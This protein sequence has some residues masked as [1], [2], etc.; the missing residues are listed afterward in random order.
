M[1]QFLFTL[2]LLYSTPLTFNAQLSW[3][4]T[5]GPYGSA[6]NRLKSINNEVYCATY[7]GIYSTN[8]NGV[9]WTSRNNGLDGCVDFQDIEVINNKLIAG[10]SNWGGFITYEPGI[11]ISND[12]GL[13]WT[14]SNT[15]LLDGSPL[16]D[17]HLSIRDIFINGNDILIGTQDG[18][19]K[20]TNFGQSWAPS[21]IGINEPN[22]IQAL[23][24][25]KSG[26]A[27]FLETA[28]DIYKSIDN[29]FTWIDLNNNIGANPFSLVANSA[30]LFCTGSLGLYKSTNNGTS[31]QLVANNLP[32]LPTQLYESNGV[33]Y[34]AIPNIGT[35][36]STNNGVSW[37]VFDSEWYNDF[38]FINNT[39]YVCNN[40]GVLSCNTNLSFVN[41]GLGEAYLTN[42]LYVDGD[43]IY[44]GTENG[45]YKSTDDG[46]LWKNMR[47]GLP[48]STNVKCITK[49][50]PS[51]IIGTKDSGVYISTDNGGTWTQ[52]N[53]GLIL[54]GTN[55]WNISMLYSINGK[56]YVGAKQ[57]S[58][59]YD[60]AALFVSNNNGQSWTPV[61]TG[62]GDN[63]FITS[64]SSFGNYL[65]LGTKTEFSPPSFSDGVYLSTDSGSSWLFDG[66]DLPITD[67]ASDNNGYYAISGLSVY[68]TLNMGNT[69]EENVL[70]TVNYPLTGIEKLNSIVVAQTPNSGLLYLNNGNWVPI[71]SFGLLGGPNKAICQKQN[72]NM[73]IGASAYT[74]ANNGNITYVS[75]GVSKY[76][77]GTVGLDKIE[78]TQIKYYPNP[79]NSKIILD[80]PETYIGNQLE[81]YD[82][83]GRF[84][85][86]T[87]ITNSSPI[88]DL[89]DLYNGVY[90]MKIPEA[91]F[92]N[93]KIVKQ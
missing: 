62:L 22:N 60:N 14:L 1:K 30:G 67:I 87:L 20:S 2:F 92:Q 11:Y 90:I 80:L 48:I 18:V 28:N 35:Y 24:F 29:G 65:I 64:M 17:L 16:Q 77:G 59:F 72:G 56:V 3:A 44:S 75:N 53:S 79:T 54:N 5:N 88:V 89:S 71:G 43:I 37:Y 51:L 73:F 78:E 4:P 91:G 49:S 23:H 7:C 70:S 36:I 31:W 12:N 93:I 42:A 6:C 21:N 50:G 34:C 52:S 39:H 74:N 9:S 55:C 83:F 40:K 41:S 58:T 19:F 32:D 26:S 63:F 84:V 57:N 46:N 27:I 82:Q 61:T 45:I 47:T 38:L 13:N 8:D 68:S 25:V 86:S 66:L 33:L 81:V 10:T 15:G 69:W 85:K 76:I